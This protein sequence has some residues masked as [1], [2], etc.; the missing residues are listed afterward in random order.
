MKKKMD[1]KDAGSIFCPALYVALFVVTAQLLMLFVSYKRM[2]WISDA[3]THSMTD[4]LLGACTLNEEELY[5]Y[6]RTGELVIIH[7][8]EKYDMFQTILKEELGLTEAMETGTGSIPMAEGKIRTSDF[9]VYS[10]HGRDVTIHD[11]DETGGYTSEVL[12]G[13]TGNLMLENGEFIESTSLL[14]EVSFQVRFFG[15]PIMVS[16][17]H[18]VD[19]TT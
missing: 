8:R 1:K 4:A 15:V 14:A 9:K 19:V 12:P 3:V 6:G 16:K 17:Y 2:M 18:M 5:H 7:P 10:V 13:R 11:F